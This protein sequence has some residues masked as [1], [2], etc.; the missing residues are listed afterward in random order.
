MASEKEKRRKRKEPEEARKRI[1]QAALK[2]FAEDGFEGARVDRIAEIAGV[3]KAMLYYHVGGKEALYEAVLMEN[4]ERLARALEVAR[5]GGK[6]PE[7]QMRRVLDALIRTL[8]EIPEHPRIMARELSA[9]ATHLPSRAVDEMTRVF[10]IVKGILEEGRK[11]GVF[12]DVNPM[13]AHLSIVGSTVFL[14]ASG[15]IRQRFNEVLQAHGGQGPGDD[16]LGLGIA[17]LVL[18]GI[19]KR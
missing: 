15:P 18:N 19:R 3:N 17:D 11:S 9:G 10:G 2:A 1:L 7:E 12:R 8:N 16:V 14:I 4:F 5:Q 13:L 6:D